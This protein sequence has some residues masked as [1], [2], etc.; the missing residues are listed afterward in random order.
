MRQKQSLGLWPLGSFAHTCPSYAQ[1]D[2]GMLLETIRQ[3]IIR[4][5]RARLKHT[6]FLRLL[7]QYLSQRVVKAA[8]R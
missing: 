5:P 1:D 4:E 8:P 7:P 6:P 3:E 2:F